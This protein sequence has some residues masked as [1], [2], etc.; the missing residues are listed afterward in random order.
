MDLFDERTRRFLNHHNTRWALASFGVLMSIQFVILVAKWPSLPSEVPLFYSRPWGEDQLVSPL[1]LL[2]LPI[3]SVVCFII[4][5]VFARIVFGRE[6]LLSTLLLWSI[7]L[8]AL[9]A[10]IGLSKIIFLVS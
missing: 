9:L 10:T 8:M 2:V 5:G 7:V 3:S 1:W 4:N 6:T